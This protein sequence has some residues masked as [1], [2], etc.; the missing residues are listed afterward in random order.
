[1]ILTAI[2]SPNRALSVPANGIFQNLVIVE[3]AVAEGVVDS[4]PITGNHCHYIMILTMASAFIPYLTYPF[5]QIH[6]CI[7]LLVVI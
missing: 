1:V 7:R 2:E 3:Y 6:E 5:L 4:A